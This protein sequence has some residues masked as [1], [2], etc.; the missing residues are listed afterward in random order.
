[1]ITDSAKLVFT[2]ARLRPTQFN[3]Y[4]AGTDRVRFPV[5]FS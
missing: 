1:M 5:L 3:P 4:T 2:L